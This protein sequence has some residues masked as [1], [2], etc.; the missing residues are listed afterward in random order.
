MK[1]NF[2]KSASLVL[3]AV[4]AMSFSAVKKDVKQIKTRESKVNWVGKKQI[5]SDHYGTINIQNGNLEFKAGKDKLV[6][7]MIMVDMTSIVVTDLEGDYKNKLEGHLKSDDFFGTNNYKSSKLVFTK[8]SKK[9]GLY[10][11]V[12]DLTIKGITESITFDLKISGNT[13]TTK[14]N[15]DRTKF[16]IKYGSS[17]F[18]DDLKDK[19]IKN[20]FELNVSL[21]F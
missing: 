12:G 21:V 8:V 1:V 3:V 20:D 7:G 2:L 5:G 13:A 14:L 11:V 17:S 19:A 10:T 18:F 9:K 4:V 6:G 16:G 15:I